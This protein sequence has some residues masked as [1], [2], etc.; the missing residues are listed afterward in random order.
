MSGL[1]QFSK[2]EETSTIKRLWSLTVSWYTGNSG[3]SA[4]WPNACLEMPHNEGQVWS[5]T[6]HNPL[7][8]RQHIGLARSP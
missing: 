3:G 6:P 8:S 2:C 4:V 7:L 5:L 1:V